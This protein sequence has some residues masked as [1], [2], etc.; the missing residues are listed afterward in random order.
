MRCLACCNKIAFTHVSWD[1]EINRDWKKKMRKMKEKRKNEPTNERIAFEKCN[2]CVI[3]SVTM[4]TN[5]LVLFTSCLQY[6][7]NQKMRYETSV[8]L[9]TMSVLVK[10]CQHLPNVGSNIN[11]LNC[12]LN[13]TQQWAKLNRTLGKDLPNNPWKSVS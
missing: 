2:M 13:L 7:W 5:R 4:V 8:L 1:L 11:S 10:I 9:R 12:L 3:L 6:H